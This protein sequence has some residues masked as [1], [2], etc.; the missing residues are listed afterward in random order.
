MMSLITKRQFLISSTCF[1]LWAPVSHA[2]KPFLHYNITDFGAEPN[3]DKLMT[4][5]IQATIEA[6]ARAGGGVVLV[7]PGRYMSGGLKL[8]S[9]V[10]LYLSAGATIKASAN[11]TDFHDTD[12]LIFAKGERNIGIAGEGT[13]DGHQDAYLRRDENG[14]L[15]GGPTGLGGPYDPEPRRSSRTK[16]RPR[17]IFLVDCDRVRI[18]DILLTNAATWTAHLMACRNMIIDGVTIDNDLDVPNNDGFDIDHCRHVRVSN[19]TIQTGDDAICFKTTNE[20]PEYGPCEDIVVTNC[21]LMS[22]SSAVKLG[23]AGSE[24]I[25]NIVV[26]NCTIT[27]SNRGVAIQNRDGALWENIIF[28]DMTINT[29]HFSPDRWGSAEPI[30]ATNLQRTADQRSM[31]NIRGVFF[32]DII[33][34]S[35]A[36]AYL[37]G[38]PVGSVEDI[39]MD[40]VLLNIV[41][42]HSER[43][44]F[45]DLRPSYKVKGARPIEIAGITAHGLSGL[46]LNNVDVRF[47]RDIVKGYGPALR[48]SDST[49]VNSSGLRGTSAFPGIIPDTIG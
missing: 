12:A 1:G 24:P 14:R 20:H 3:T 37:Y 39:V 26:S 32:K 42:P 44:G 34:H 43:F 41:A 16:G 19:C 31:G 46:Q 40:N 35:E 7:P 33:C 11:R 15:R 49:R 17:I 18:R 8:R 38:D 4:R 23:S 22:Q 47:A 6:C 45:D 48:I 5:A 2:A 9:N 27:D 36:G 13:L 21:T 25:R 28:S 10:T 29:R 30:Y